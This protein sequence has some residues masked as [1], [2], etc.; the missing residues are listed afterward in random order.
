MYFT[1]EDFGKVRVASLMPMPQNDG[2]F[3]PHSIGWHC[4]NDRYCIKRP[5]GIS[6][7]L[8]L[9]TVKGKGILRLGNREYALLPGTIAFVPRDMAN[10]YFT[11][12]GG[13]WEFY[14]I[15]PAEGAATRFLDVF[16]QRGAYLAKFDPSDEFPQRV[17][18]LI[19]LCSGH[20]P[21]EWLVSEAFSELLHRAAITL[22]SSSSAH[23]VSNKAIAY[24]DRHFR[25][26]IVLEEIAQAQ[27]LSTAHFIRIFK[28]ETGRTPHQYLTERRLLFA[29]QLLEFGGRPIVEVA[30]RSGFSSASHF[31]SSFRRY[32]GCTPL[33][34]RNQFFASLPDD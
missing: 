22:D 12:K 29:A 24:M 7:H 19:A 23:S 2:I 3:A 10:S 4:C 26:P 15:H 13:V 32:Y 28:K 11:P 14:W 6:I 25:E 30:A 5:E 16:A 34:F 17:E 33:Q 9:I 1:E 27:F 8:F 20:P 21:D 18:D 31:I